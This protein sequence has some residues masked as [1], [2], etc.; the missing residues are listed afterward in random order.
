[1]SE[2]EQQ[3][4]MIAKALEV[5][6]TLATDALD[7]DIELAQLLAVG[8]DTIAKEASVDSNLL[9]HVLERQVELRREAGSAAHIMGPCEAV[10]SALRLLSEAP[11]EPR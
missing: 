8:L 2:L 11:K 9:I 10:L 1:M 7:R 3:I 5:A 6:Q 4:A